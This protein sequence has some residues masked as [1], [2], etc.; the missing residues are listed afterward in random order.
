MRYN[1]NIKI[2]LML[3][4]SLQLFCGLALAEESIFSSLYSANKNK[5]I[6]IIAEK[7]WTEQD[8]VP[9]DARNVISDEKY[10]NPDHLPLGES[11]RYIATI[12]PQAGKGTVKLALDYAG[13]TNNTKDS[14]ILVSVAFECPESSKMSD[15][16]QSNTKFLDDH[17]VMYPFSQINSEYSINEKD[18]STEVIING[19][20]TKLFLSHSFL[21]YDFPPNKPIT[22]A[23]SFSASED[24]KTHQLR[25]TLL[26]GDYATSPPPLFKAGQ[27]YLKI[28]KFARSLIWLSLIF[29]IFLWVFK[30]NSQA[31]RNENAPKTLGVLLTIWC[32]LFITAGSLLGDSADS[33]SYFL[34]IGTIFAYS[35]LYF[36]LGKHIALWFWGVGLATAWGL[37][38]LEVGFHFKP[39]FTQVGFISLLSLYIFSNRVTQRLDETGVISPY[40]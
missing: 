32:G 38:I 11:T 34:I 1:E 40:E 35:A 37:S 3:C 13:E 26:Y 28:G 22:I 25:T 18:N 7:I 15:C 14:D 2:V 30:L 20:K 16:L 9:K 39:L 12:T 19:Q 33:L 36:Y 31:P 4:A 10:H 27:G 23:I 24:T 6:E 5:P 21:E 8:E 29:L 17:K